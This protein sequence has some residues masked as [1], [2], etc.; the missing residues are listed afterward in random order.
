MGEGDGEG[1]VGGE[2]EGGVALAPVFYYG[3]VDGGGGAGAVDCWGGGGGGH[4]G[5]GVVFVERCGDVEFTSQPYS[6][7]R[8]MP[9]APKAGP[10]G[11]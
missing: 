4:G 10:L 3:N 8:L 9:R 7:T 11:G 6:L 1:G 2:V 5:G